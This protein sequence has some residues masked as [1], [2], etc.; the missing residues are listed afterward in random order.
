MSSFYS[1]ASLDAVVSPVAQSKKHPSRSRKHSTHHQIESSNAAGGALLSTNIHSTTISAERSKECQQD[2]VHNGNSLLH[3]SFDPSLIAASSSLHQLHTSLTNI[4]TSSTHSRTLLHSFSHQHENLSA[5]MQQFQRQIYDWRIKTNNLQ[6]TM[7]HVET[8]RRYFL[9]VLRLKREKPTVDL[10]DT[11]LQLQQYFE[12][13]QGFMDAPQAL[14]KLKEV[15]QR[16]VTALEDYFKK[17]VQMERVGMGIVSRD[18]TKQNVPQTAAK[19]DSTQDRE[20]E[21]MARRLHHLGIWSY[22]RHYI[23]ARRRILKRSLFG[24]KKIGVDNVMKKVGKSVTSAGIHKS[25]YQDRFYEPGTHHFIKLMDEFIQGLRRER[26]VLK[27]L[28]FDTKTSMSTQKTTSRSSKAKR[29]NADPL[30]QSSST[31]TASSSTAKKSSTSHKKG[32]DDPLGPDGS[33]SG[34]LSEEQKSVEQVFEDVVAKAKKRFFERAEAIGD[35]VKQSERVFV[36]LDVLDQFE[37]KV[38]EFDPIIKRDELNQ[39]QKS[40]RQKISSYLEEYKLVIQSMSKS[41]ATEPG[42]VHQATSNSFLLFHRLLSY[43]ETVEN[44]LG[45]EFFGETSSR[46]SIRKK[47]S[48]KSSFGRYMR[49]IIENATEKAIEQVSSHEKNKALKLLFLINNHHYILEKLQNEVFGQHI[50]ESYTVQYEQ[51]FKN[52]IEEFN[53]FVWKPLEETV[54][55]ME[56]IDAAKG[57]AE[58]TSKKWRRAIKIRFKSFNSKFNSITNQHAAFKVSHAKIGS[59][60]RSSAEDIICD[61]YEK[62]YKKYADQPFSKKNKNKYLEFTPQTVRETIRQMYK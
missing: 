53:N 49:Y 15:R 38:N 48:S 54:S 3:T 52:D 4:H 47:R 14:E 42:Q 59:E 39:L 46:D 20:L 33:A 45:T 58:K 19:Q 60:L 41:D 23:D 30:S 10:L 7:R 43:E 24:S 5:S 29:R 8:V 1:N 21:R 12:T 11:V 57:K 61:K 2:D 34:G 50:H 44:L 55:N 25:K 56:Q 35:D 16:T 36:L 62:F 31:S 32:H 51:L 6:E 17:R 9:E 37:K 28:I 22:R 40:L 13:K 26:E 27:M 18:G